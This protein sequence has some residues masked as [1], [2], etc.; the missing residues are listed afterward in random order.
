MVFAV[1]GLCACLPR[2]IAVWPRPDFSSASMPSNGQEKGQVQVSTS[3]NVSSS[4]PLARTHEDIGYRIEQSPFFV[5]E[6][7]TM[8]LAISLLALGDI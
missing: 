6:N 1:E 4:A 5:V 2:R 8:S 3:T 7:N